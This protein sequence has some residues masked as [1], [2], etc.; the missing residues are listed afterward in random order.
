MLGL[1]FAKKKLKVPAIFTGLK[2]KAPYGFKE[3]F[4]KEEL[5]TINQV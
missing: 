1:I 4:H 3:P 2:S 5:A